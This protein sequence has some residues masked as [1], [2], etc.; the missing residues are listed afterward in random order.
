MFDWRL[1]RLVAINQR[2]VVQIQKK[3]HRESF[4]QKRGLWW[5]YAETNNFKFFQKKRR[6]NQ[7][8]HRCQLFDE[9]LFGIRKNTQQ[10]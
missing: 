10:V 3:G 7:F 9:Y 1:N 2:S 4:H 5:I 8:L 6:E